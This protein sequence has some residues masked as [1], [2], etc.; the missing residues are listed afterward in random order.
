MDIRN[1]WLAALRSGNYK[2]GKLRLRDSSNRFCVLGVLCDVVDPDRWALPAPRTPPYPW[3]SF[4]LGFDANL[5]PDVIEIAGLR[6]KNAH[7]IGAPIDFVYSNLSA[8]NDRMKLT[9]EEMADI[10]EA[11]SD[12]IFVK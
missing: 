1:K 4:G 12:D 7:L 2:K 6:S 3:Y 8:V 5:P 9:F 10:I 11:R